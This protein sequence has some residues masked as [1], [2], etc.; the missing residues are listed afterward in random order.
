M[1][2]CL[3]VCV[4]LCLC[5]SVPLCLCVYVSMCLCVDLLHSYLNLEGNRLSGTI[6]TQLLQWSRLQTLNL[7]SNSLTGTLPLP[8]SRIRYEL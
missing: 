1:S 6:P 2:V 8:F 3:C 7:R 5:V 4:P